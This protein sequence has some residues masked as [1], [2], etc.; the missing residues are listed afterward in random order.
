M[1]RKLIIT[2]DDYGMCNSV[3][4]AVETC[5]AAGTIRATCVM[6]NM[7]AY[8]AAATLRDR[9]PQVSIGVHWTLTQGLPVLPMSQVPSLVSADGKFHPFTQF[10]RRWLAKQVTQ[11][12]VKAELCAQY[13]RL[14]E[15]A[16]P[17]DFW[18][19]HED[20]HMSPGMFETCVALGLKLGI[21][22]M[23]CHRRIV[24][25]RDNTPTS[26]SL[27][28][29][30]FWLKG[31]VI[32]RWSSW[33]EAQGV[34]M[35]DGRIHLVG[36]SNSQAAIEGVTKLLQWNSISKAVEW[37]IHPATTIEEELFG[38]LTE[39]RVREYQVFSDPRLVERLHKNGVQ[40]IGF[41][42]LGNDQ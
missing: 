3:N 39:S 25:L 8:A 27:S 31:Q 5:L 21:P 1:S 16:G 12:E 20:V 10:R 14:Y 29:P 2:A 35:P 30:L 6:T 17:L 37:T 38:V 13:Q 34:L 4:E 28:H 9:F 22:A 7:P 41:E 19:T 24:V 40:T 33:A 18:N 15:V 42:V 11:A 36:Y 32:A 23:R 26:Y